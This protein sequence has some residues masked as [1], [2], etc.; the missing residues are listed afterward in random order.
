MNI[1]DVVIILFCITALIRGVELGVVRQACSTIGLFVGLF[2]GAFIQ[3]ELIGLVH[4]PASKALLSLVIIVGAI[5]LFSGIG[6][7]A[8]VAIRSRIE[9]ARRL[10]IIDKADRALGSIVAGA[11]VLLVVWLAAAIFSSTPLQLLQRQ[12]NNSVIIAQLNKSLPPAPD[13]VSKLG[14]LIDPNGFPEVFTGLEPRIDTDTPLP[15][16]GEL[17]TAVQQTRASVV[18]IEGAGC[19]GISQGSGFVA[20]TNLVITNA[21]VVAGVKQPYILDANGR[22]QAQ[23]LWFDRDLDMAVLKAGG[24]AGEPLAMSA[25]LANNGDKAAVLGYPGG[26]D[27]TANP[28]IILDTFQAE[29]RDIYNQG[30]TGRQVYSIKSAIEPGNSG[31]PL[32]NKDGVVV[33]LIFAESTTYDQVGYALTMEKVIEGLNVARDRSQ[34]V[35]TGNCAH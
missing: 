23:V 7:Y 29:G 33:G 11:T 21:H 20:D 24:L 2:L 8:G 10:K 17:D 34:T 35:G 9:R 12:L 4:S 32:I 3:G 25:G 1:V 22:H 14:H 26:G 15:S 5:A 13:V 19:G 27:F 30:K 28:A 6:E 18:K 31:G 16:I